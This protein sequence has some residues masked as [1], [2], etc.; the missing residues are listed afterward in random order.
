LG[1]SCTFRG[2]INNIYLYHSVLS[3]LFARG[4]SNNFFFLY[5]TIESTITKMITNYYHRYLGT[6]GV[7]TDTHAQQ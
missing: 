5:T 3:I 6:I 7:N 1:G 2:I 4:C